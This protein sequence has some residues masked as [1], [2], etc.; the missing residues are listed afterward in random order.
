MADSGKWWKGIIDKITGDSG[1]EKMTN[2]EL[3][4][5]KQHVIS[6]LKLDAEADEW[7]EVSRLAKNVKIYDKLIKLQ[8]DITKMDARQMAEKME[9]L[10]D[11]EFKP[12]MPGQSGHDEFLKKVEALALGFDDDD[13]DDG[14]F[15]EFGA[16]KPK[17]KRRKSRKR[18]SRKRK[19]RK[20]KSKKR[21]RSSKKS[22]RR[23]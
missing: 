21:K 17:L 16:M 22:R 20:I 2:E 8:K 4:S 19:S 1:L 23:R 3:K 9:E 11:E 7:E 5:E 12:V 10:L 14:D 15:S 18:K 6:Q 13:G